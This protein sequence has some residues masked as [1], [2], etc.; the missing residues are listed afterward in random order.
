MR[1]H[2]IA[3]AALLLAFLLPPAAAPCAGSPS[4]PSEALGEVLPSEDPG[5]ASETLF[6][7]VARFAPIASVFA[8]KA[9]GVEGASS[10]KRL[11]VNSAASL[12]ISC[13]TTWALKYTIHEERPDHSDHHSF[14]SGH[15]TVAFA[16][17]H[18]LCKE[19]ARKSPWIA[20]AGYGVAAAVAADRVAQDRHHWQ[21]VCA[22]AA[23]GILGTELGYWLG[24][25]LTGERSRY[26]V[27]VG[28]QSVAM[29][30]SF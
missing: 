19:Y 17:A 14:P 15:T 10:W 9:C 13:G 22:G 20:V 25:R 28:P 27:S 1:T 2:L 3:T 30:I 16:G 12:V 29:V 24:D 8:L 7:S 6:A 23:I 26:S 11:V 18:V 4:P 5:E 21:D